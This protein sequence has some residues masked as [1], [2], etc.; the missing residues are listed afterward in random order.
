[1]MQ[2]DWQRMEAMAIEQEAEQRRMAEII[3]YMQ[4]LGAAMGV[5]P[6]PTLFA[7][8]PSPHATSPI[9]MNVLVCMFMLTV[10][11]Q[12]YLK[13]SATLMVYIYLVSHTC[14]LFSFMQNQSA[15]SNSVPRHLEGSPG[16]YVGPHQPG[17]SP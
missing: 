14:N 4:S 6:P 5:A 10:K 8:P 16:S 13:P 12:H 7:P 2:A 11:P 9:S 17:Q 1:M 15:A 3:Q